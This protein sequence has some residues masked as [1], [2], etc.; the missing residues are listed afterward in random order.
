MSF[1]L[2]CPICGKRDVYEFHFGGQV[3][4]PRPRQEDLSAAD[5]FRYVQ[6]RT[7]TSSPQREWW[8]HAQGCGSWF[9]TWRNPGTNREETPAEASHE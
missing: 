3:R 7:V 6:F 2:T 5:H 8:Y 1:T 4:G 9:T